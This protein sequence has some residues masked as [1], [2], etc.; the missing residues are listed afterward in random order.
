MVAASCRVT[1]DSARRPHER[2]AAVA[3]PIFSVSAARFAS[4]HTRRRVRPSSDIIA[5]GP[6]YEISSDAEGV[7]YC[8]VWRREDLDH[9]AGARCAE[10]M[11]AHLARLATSPDYTGFVYDL[12]EAP[13][14]AGP[15]TQ[16]AIGRTLE[17]WK[18]SGRRVAIAVGDA[19]MR[20]L[21]MQRIVGE[22]LAEGEGAIFDAPEEAT[23]WLLSRR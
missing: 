13:P 17:R 12:R 16:E 4:G 3:A 14:V 20:R 22:V 6:N 15:R 9:D 2:G 19:A 5:S 1:S 11:L 18:D 7:V 21:Q 8:R 23:A 10:E